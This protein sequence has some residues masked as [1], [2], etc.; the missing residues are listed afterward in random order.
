MFSLLVIFFSP[1]LFF[2]FFFLP[3]VPWNEPYFTLYGWEPRQDV[4][5]REWE[6]A[7]KPVFTAD[8]LSM[9]VSPNFRRLKSQRFFNCA[10]FFVK[11]SFFFT[12]SPREN[13]IFIFGGV[14][15]NSFF[16]KLRVTYM[17]DHNRMIV[18]HRQSTHFP[19][20]PPSS[21]DTLSSLIFF[22]SLPHFF[23]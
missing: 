17:I 4:K 20:L 13:F 8:L 16:L 19:P 11:V 9:S 2:F 3:Y 12:P 7:R 1:F 5:V 6:C 23:L 14:D 15:L 21:H 10:S 18:L 22:F